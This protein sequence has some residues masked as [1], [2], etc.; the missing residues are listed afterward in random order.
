MGYNCS[1]DNVEK[2]LFSLKQALE[3]VGFLA[4][5]EKYHKNKQCRKYM[6]K[7]L[8]E[9]AS[10]GREA[11]TRIIFFKKIG[12]FAVLCFPRE[13]KEDEKKFRKSKFRLISKS[14][15]FYLFLEMLNF[16]RNEKEE[17]RSFCRMEKRKSWSELG[18][19]L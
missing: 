16:K 9:R 5:I 3:S 17:E 12:I 8:L 10:S 1:E 18:L 19:D 7:F 2:E 15:N 4:Q 14:L 11:L 6:K 13:S